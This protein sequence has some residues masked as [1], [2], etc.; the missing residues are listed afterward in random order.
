MPRPRYHNSPR[1]TPRRRGR[2][3]RTK[4]DRIRPLLK[5]VALMVFSP[6]L[7]PLAL[8]ILPP[9][10][11]KDYQDRKKNPPPPPSPPRPIDPELERRRELARRTNIKKYPFS[12]LYDP[13]RDDPTYAWAIKEAGQRASEEIGYN[14]MG[15]CHRI[16]RRMKEILKDEFDIVWYSPRE[17]NPDVRYD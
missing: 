9:I 5:F 1:P 14:Q 3:F 17:M 15:D 10:I 2:L 8:L 12:H 16:W 7:I 4:R 13:I 11:W 6:I